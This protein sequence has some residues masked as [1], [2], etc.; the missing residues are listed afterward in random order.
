MFRHF[1]DVPISHSKIED[2]SSE[3]SFI[4]TP[5]R[6]VI[7]RYTISLELSDLLWFE[8]Q[9]VE[10]PAYANRKSAWSASTVKFRWVVYIFLHWPGSWL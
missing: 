9:S 4:N 10:F 1:H 5:R 3:Y 6:K 7:Y 2:A 8:I